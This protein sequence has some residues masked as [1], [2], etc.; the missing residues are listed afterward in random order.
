[1]RCRHDDVIQNSW[2]LSKKKAQCCKLLTTQG[3]QKSRPC[4]AINLTE[5]ESPVHAC[6]HPLC[7]E[8]ISIYEINIIKILQLSYTDIL[9]FQPCTL[10]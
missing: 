7:A 2:I 6:T 3:N 1:M 8:N 10:H 9:N 4:N 5:Y